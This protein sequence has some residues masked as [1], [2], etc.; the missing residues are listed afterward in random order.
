MEVKSLGYVVISSTDP[1]KWLDFGTNV[2]GMM[3]GSSLPDSG[4][5]YLRMDQRPFRYAIENGEFDGLLYAGWD[6]GSEA[7]FTKA[8]TE[9]NDKGI[10]VETIDDADVLTSRAVS[11]LARLA[12]PSGNR[13][14]L[15]WA[16]DAIANDATPFKSPL[17]VKGFITTANNG[18]D[19]GLGHVV[20]HAPIDYE[21]THDFYQAMGFVD[22]DVTV[23]GGDEANGKIYFMRCNPRHHSLALWNWGAP[24][25]ETN[26]MPSP[27]SKA[28][29]CVHLMAEVASLGEVGSC[30]DRVTEREIMIISTLG[31]HINDEMVS[32]YMLTPG[33][34]ALE[35]GYDGLQLDDSHKTT[36]NI[37]PSKWGHKWAG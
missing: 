10:A 25:P 31:E 27:E 18:E 17:D 24:T 30:L 20:L 11:G 3:Q 34:F 28:P 2:V 35:F 36:H 13:L 23:L 16:T 14:E 9:L 15:F 37:M 19:M 29:G 22:A 6:M 21:A 26:F 5:V 8:V 4:A 7:D 1:E 32:F 12:D 33:M